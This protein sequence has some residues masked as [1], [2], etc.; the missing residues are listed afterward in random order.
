MIFGANAGMGTELFK[1]NCYS[2]MFC[3]TLLKAF[4]LVHRRVRVKKMLCGV[5]ETEI[6][7]LKF[8]FA[9]KMKISCIYDHLFP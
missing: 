8:L 9:N 5:D 6:L 3:L 2:V 1:S 4:L 7:I